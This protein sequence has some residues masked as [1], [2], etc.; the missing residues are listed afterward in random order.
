VNTAL[1]P[2]TP[3]TVLVTGAFSD[4]GTG[5]GGTWHLTKG[6]IV[7]DA[8]KLKA[9][10]NSA[11]FG[12]FYPASCSFQ[13]VASATVT[14]VSG[15]GAYAG[16]TG[17]IL[18]TETVAAQGSLLKNGKCNEANNAPSVAE[19]LIATGSGTVSFK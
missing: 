18:A 12:T 9:I 13:G 4:H 5:Q 1:N 19:A 2:T 6:S 11:N 15:T 17:R 7:I 16:I 3:N 8:S 10:T 14:L